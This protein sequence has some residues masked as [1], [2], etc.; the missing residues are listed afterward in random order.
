MRR[1]RQKN[2]LL[3]RII[4][5]S[6]I[7]HIIL[8]PIL[9]HFGAFKKIQAHFVETKMV[10]LAPPSA[11]PHQEPPKAVQRKT[12]AAV[13][14]G[15]S[16]GAK[17]GASHGS[18]NH[19]HVAVA[20]NGGTD[21]DG[22]SGIEQGNQKPGELPNAGKQTTS[23]G[24]PDAPAPAPVTPKDPPKPTITQ[25]PVD[26]PVKPVITPVTPMP[27]AP[28]PAHVAV[29]TEAAPIEGKQVQPEI[30]DTLRNDPLDAT[31]VV[32]VNVGPDGV[33][34][35]VEVSQSAG[36]KELDN[37]ALNAAKQW[38]FKPAMR[39]GEPISSKVRLHF[40]FQVN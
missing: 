31:A 40:E 11:A 35:G 21:G 28:M 6:V 7:A 14:R 29:F 19:V 36:R 25:Q 39:D 20:G 9:A 2:P 16:T 23:G 38:R 4:V 17:S 22:G 15:K 8:L 10:V 37:L 1:R 26:P 32:E 18:A 30:P 33:P 12:A 3:M 13:A 34:T 5:I 27:P 24:K